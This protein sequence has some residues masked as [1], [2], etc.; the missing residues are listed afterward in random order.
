VAVEGGGGVGYRHFHISAK[1]AIH[2]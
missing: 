2:G 1:F